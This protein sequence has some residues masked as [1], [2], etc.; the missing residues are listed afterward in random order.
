MARLMD[1]FNYF[2]L[3]ARKARDD[4]NAQKM[5]GLIGNAPMPA[6]QYDIP[7]Q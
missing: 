7:M 2:A 4:Y 3:Q 1:P 6:T 5:Q